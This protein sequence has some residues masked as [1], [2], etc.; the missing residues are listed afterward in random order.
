M[1]FIY[2][3]MYNVNF[4]VWLRF[5]TTNLI[6]YCVA[7][8]HATGLQRTTWIGQLSEDIL[9]SWLCVSLR[10]FAVCSHTTCNLAP[11]NIS[12]ISM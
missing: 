12:I 8:Y 10:N 4:L 7:I 2:A 1:Y 3:N 6:L 11:H 5:H 9:L